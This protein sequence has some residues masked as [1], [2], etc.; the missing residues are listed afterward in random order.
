MSKKSCFRGPFQRQHGKQ[1]LTLFKSASLHVYHTYW[2]LSRRFSCKK[3]ILVIC[4]ILRLFVNI[5]AANDK[6]VGWQFSQ[7]QKSYSRFFSAF[8]K[9]GLNLEHFEKQDDPHRFCISET[10]DSEN[11]VRIM[12]KISNFRVPC[13]KQHGK[14]AQGLLKHESQHLYHIPSSL[15]SHL[16]QKKS[17]LLKCQILGLFVNTLPSDEKYPVL[18]R[19]NLTISIQM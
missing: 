19:D 6:Y 4:Q 13:D 3:F 11:V 2:S 8:F 1:A 17:L 5:L 12:S 14:R 9:C 15:Q 10:T 18:N 7:K 16:S